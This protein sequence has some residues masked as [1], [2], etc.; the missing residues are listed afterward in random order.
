MGFDGG[1]ELRALS[2]EVSEWISIHDYHLAWRAGERRPVVSLDIATGLVS[3]VVPS[4]VSREFMTCEMVDV[5]GP[6][7]SLRTTGSHDALLVARVLRQEPQVDWREVRRV[8]CFRSLRLGGVARWSWMSTLMEALERRD[9]FLV[10]EPSR[11]DGTLVPRVVPHEECWFERRQCA[12]PI[13]GVWMP[14]LD[15][16][17]V[18]RCGSC[19]VAA[20]ASC[21]ARED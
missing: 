21:P 15:D 9:G 16:A 11:D 14:G 5:R 7:L 13:Y 12:G 19:V 4:E 6:G 17:L 20:C 1:V 2:R 8:R 10:Y 3:H 18:V